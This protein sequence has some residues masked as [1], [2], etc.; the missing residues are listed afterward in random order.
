MTYRQLQQG[1]FPNLP[2]SLSLSLFVQGA[3]ADDDDNA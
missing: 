2:L 1:L 3:A